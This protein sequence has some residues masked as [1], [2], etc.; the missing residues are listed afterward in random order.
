MKKLGEFQRNEKNKKIIL[1]IEFIILIILLFYVTIKITNTSGN[2]S[3]IAL[4][5]ADI[6]SGLI[7]LNVNFQGSGT[8]SDG[9]IVSYFWDFGDGITSK[10]QNPT[11]TYQTHGKFTVTF[12][13]ADNKGDIGRNKII[14]DVM[15]NTQTEIKS[16]NQQEYFSDYIYFDFNWVPQYPDVGEKTTFRVIN[17]YGGITLSKIWNFG[18][19]SIGW[20]SVVSHTYTKKGRYRVSLSVSGREF[21][22]EKYSSG[23]KINYIEIGASPFPRFTWAPKEPTVG[24]KINFDA[25]ESKDV[26]GKIVKY[27]WS[28]TEASKPNTIINMGNNK[29]FIYTF[30]KQG[31]Y[32][33]KLAVTDNENNTNELIK[34]VI[35]S[36]LSIK[37]IIGGYRNFEFQITNRG[38]IT[39]ENINWK[40]FVNRNLLFIPLWKICSKTGTLTIL[41][42]GETRTIDVGRYRRGFGRI[43]VTIIAEGNNA[44][45]IT[46]SQQGFMFS[47]FIHLRS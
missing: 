39:A 45:K 8:D 18:D 4:A 27:S 22:T 41:R 47:K 43:T 15:D 5:S 17:Y 26:N 20:G 10:S 13:V 6:T 9:I 16:T 32:K 37:E 3:P 34:T 25:S 31:N 24:E 40:V 19:G 35:V 42:P 12:T 2:F 7:P 29:Y 46:R 33:V 1:A 36:I 21:F 14:V 30:N 11:H 38:N 28:Y 44:V 23:Y